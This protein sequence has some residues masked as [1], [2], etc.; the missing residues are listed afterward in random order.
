[1]GK[2]KIILA[3]KVSRGCGVWCFALQGFVMMRGNCRGAFLAV[4]IVCWGHSCGE[5]MSVTS[6]VCHVKVIIII[7]FASL[8]CVPVLISNNFSITQVRR[9]VRVFI[10]KKKG[11]LDSRVQGLA[12]LTSLFI[13]I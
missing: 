7:T 6:F 4:G 9:E 5:D 1:M 8:W 10:S 11:I 2:G 12:S 3:R 13:F